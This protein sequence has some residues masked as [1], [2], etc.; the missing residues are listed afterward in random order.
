MALGAGV[1]QYGCADQYLG[2][3]GEKI[4]KPA[5]ARYMTFYPVG[6]GED[7]EPDRKPLSTNHLW[8]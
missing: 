6:R 8:I 3:T 2:Y 7:S 5:N 4:I 1:V